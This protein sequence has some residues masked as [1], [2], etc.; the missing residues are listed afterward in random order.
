[1]NLFKISWSAA[2]FF[3][4]CVA[5]AQSPVDTTYQLPAVEISTSRM[6]HFS[7]GSKIQE[8]DSSLLSQ[9][10]ANNLADILG[11]ESSLFIKSYG[12]GSLATT[13]FRGGNAAHTAVLWN[14][15]NINSPMNGTLDLSLVPINFIG[16]A[17]IQYGGSSALWGSGAVGGTIHLNTQP[18]FNDG[19]LVLARSSFGSFGDYQQQMQVQWSKTRWASSIKLFNHVAENNFPFYNALESGSPKKLQNNAQLNQKGILA[20]NY[21]KINNRQLINFCAWL[22]QS[23]RNIPP[24]LLQERN[25]TNQ[26]DNTYRFTSQWQ[27]TGG[28]VADYYIRAAWF[29]EGLTY[30]DRGNNFTSLNR[31][32]SLIIEAE[33][34][35]KITQNHLV[36]IGINNTFLQATSDGYIAEAKQNRAALFA[37]Y[38]YKTTN[39]KLQTTLSGRQELFNNKLIPITYSLGAEYIVKPWMALKISAAKVYRVPTFNDLYWFPGGNPNLK[40]ESG[41]TQDAGIVFAFKSSNNRLHLS[42]EPTLFNRNMNNWILWLPNQGYWAPQNIMEV[43]SRGMETKSE[44]KYSISKFVFKIN[45]LTNY[46]VSTSEKAISSSDMSLHKQLIYVP[47]YSGQLKI[48]LQYRRFFISYLHSY[49]GYRYTSSDNTEYLK[50]YLLADLHAGYNISYKK[51]TISVFAQANNLFSEQ[52]RIILNRPMPMLNYQAGISLQYH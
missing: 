42:F 11:N 24:I 29:S 3:T 22:Q 6:Q 23:D 5:M 13:S 48:S 52:Y 50:P 35:I 2:V 32:E 18:K 1:M 7:S 43:W 14:G 40:P 15:F 33:S 45:I 41:Y 21:F 26:Q 47:M 19:L 25:N 36:N 12:L 16:K 4:A 20:E 49:T 31:A 30:T 46:V 8:L 51:Y 44:L 38:S 39:Q 37:S 28:K 9:Y 17:A 27:R 34:K 10:A